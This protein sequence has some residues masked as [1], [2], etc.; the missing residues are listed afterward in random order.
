MRVLDRFTGT[1]FI[2]LVGF[3]V[4][5]TSYSQDIDSLE[6]L[7]GRE[8]E[9]VIVTASRRSEIL[10]GMNYNT[11]VLHTKEMSL[12]P[13]R[14]MDDIF[15][16]V[17]GLNQDRKNGIFSGSQNTL[18]MMGIT[19]GQQGRVLVIE[20]GIPLNVSDNG[21][22]NWN[23]FHLSDYSRIEIIKGPA[24][25]LYGSNAMGG[26]INLVSSVPQKPFEFRT[27]LSY[28]S[29]HTAMARAD[30]S[31]KQS[32][33]YWKAGLNYHQ[34]DGY[35]MPPDSLRDS[36]DI[37][38]F[39]YEAGIRLKA[40]FLINEFLRME[41]SY[42]FYDDKHGYGLQILDEKG[43]YSSHRT[44]FSRIGLQ[45]DNRKW[46]YNLSLF[47]QREDYAK[48]IEKLKGTAYTAIDVNAA[49]EDGGMLAYIGKKTGQS[50]I[51]TGIDLRTGS[52]TGV[53]DYLTSSDIVTNHGRM[54]Q[55]SSYLHG[56]VNLARKIVKLTGSLNFTTVSLQDALFSIENPT[57]E[58]I[59]MAA[60]KET[61]S[62]TLW[63]SLNPSVS[64]KVSPL[65][66]LSFL[67]IFSRGFRT[68]TIDDLTRSGMM[69]IG[70]KEA[71]PLL[72]PEKINHYQLAVRARILPALLISGAVWYSSGMD[73]IY[74]ID[75][76]ETLFN[77]KRKVYRK[78]NINEVEASGAEMTLRWEPAE[79]L[80]AYANI[81]L[82]H[83]VI[84]KNESLEGKILSYTPGHME[85]MGIITEN[86]FFEGM[87]NLVYKGK[88]F[89]DDLNELPVPAHGIVNLYLS[90]TLAAHFKL[91]L[92]LQNVGNKT[93]LFDG[94]NL[95]LGRF[96][97]ADF[98]INF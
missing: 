75:T 91:S 14:S 63:N 35:I 68:P 3:S 40:G 71:S 85:G 52:T 37:A 53:D 10:S 93:Y 82:N 42:S 27:R 47:Y 28:G 19:G 54:V 2:L 39:L 43:G 16:M 21:E 65:T 24:S 83:S 50:V 90:K 84:R 95:T 41:A 25:N 45:Y 22:V 92:T 60:F 77:G 23:R 76:G 26:V 20:D 32:K 59:Y 11:T 94:R 17:A 70:F 29:Y 13:A 36:T 88:Q 5:S 15:S 4:C 79:W 64:L 81:S 67:L 58:T 80:Q 12:C 48:L 62:D 87:I 69:S 74:Y 66:N 38:T 34:S 30:L 73:Y 57:D 72:K 6:T 8:L 78:D 97:M 55:L 33:F 89:M 9:E 56:E 61:F 7:P 98:E 86:R 44:H 18:N 51:A 46:F 49:R 31:G 1:V 96:V